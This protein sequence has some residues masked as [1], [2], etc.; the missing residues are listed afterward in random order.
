MKYAEGSVRR[1]EIEEELRDTDFNDR[2]EWIR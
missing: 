1:K 2:Y